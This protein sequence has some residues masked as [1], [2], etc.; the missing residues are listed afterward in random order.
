MSQEERERVLKG[1]RQTRP[2][3]E[4]IEEGTARHEPV[5]VYFMDGKQ[6]TVEVYALSSAQFRQ[7]T[8]KANMTLADLQEVGRKF[9]ESKKARETDPNTPIPKEMFGESWD[10]FQS[11]AQLSVKDPPNIL[12]HILPNEEIKIASKAIEMS[13]PPKN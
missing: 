4:R 10:F 5:S 8:K 1:Q 3:A 11:L 12:E 13:Q 7:A 6:R 9:E 2:I